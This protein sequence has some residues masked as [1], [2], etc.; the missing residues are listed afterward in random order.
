MTGISL[1]AVLVGGV[2]IAAVAYVV[3]MIVKNHRPKPPG[4]GPDCGCG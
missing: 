2:M 3:V 4:C 1:D